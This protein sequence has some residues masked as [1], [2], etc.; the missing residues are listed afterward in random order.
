MNT[1]EQFRLN[2]H[3]CDKHEFWPYITVLSIN[4]KVHRAEADNPLT[5][6]SVAPFFRWFQ[7]WGYDEIAHVADEGITWI[8]GWHDDDS[9][10]AQALLAIRA[11]R[12]VA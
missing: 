10:E 6:P 1:P 2:V 4:G 12:D 5:H 8:R 7:T 9:P 3:A 11:L